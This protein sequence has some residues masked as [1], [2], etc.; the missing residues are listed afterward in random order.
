MSRNSVLFA[1]LIA[2]GFAFAS[3]QAA[4]AALFSNAGQLN[5]GKAQ[6][7]EGGI[8]SVTGET[9]TAGSSSFSGVKTTKFS[10]GDLFS[11]SISSG[12]KLAS[13][14]MASKYASFATEAGTTN[15][16]ANGLAARS[17]LLS[18]TK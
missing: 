3:A 7:A 12:V 1:A 4:D 8:A 10:G 2:S 11:T 6:L 16:F 5:G 13:A 14:D 15:L 18:L 9:G 17:S